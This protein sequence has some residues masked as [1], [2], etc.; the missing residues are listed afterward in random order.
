M[1]LLV[2]EQLSKLLA[3][4][5]INVEHADISTAQFN[6]ETRT[7]TLP[8]WSESVSND[9]YDL[10]TSHE[11]GHA[12]YT[13]VKETKA[14]L[15]DDKYPNIHF[16]VNVVEDSRIERMIKNTYPGLKKN[17]HNG[18]KELYDQD[19]FKLKDTE[20]E[21]L[22][23]IDRLNLNEKIGNFTLINFSDKEQHFA[24][25]IKKTKT[26]KEVVELSKELYVYSK[27]E[28]YLK[29]M[30]DEVSY[31]E[32]SLEDEDI[33][34][35]DD[36]D[37]IEIDNRYNFK[38]EKDNSKIIKEIQKLKE[39]IEKFEDEKETQGSHAGDN[40]FSNFQPKAKTQENLEKSVENIVVN[41][42][43]KLYLQFPELNHKD[44][45]Y[46]YKKVYN[47]IRDKKG[48]FTNKLYLTKIK[49]E[50]K[51]TVE[52]MI[53]VFETKKA[54]SFYVR[55]KVA[56]TGTIDTSK[57]FSYKYNEDIFKKVNVVPEGKNHGMI[58]LFDWSGSMVSHTKLYNC[59]KQLV[60]TVLFCRKMNIPYRV[61][62]FGCEVHDSNSHSKVNSFGYPYYGKRVTNN[63]NIKYKNYDIVSDDSNFRIVE[64]LNSEM[65]KKEYDTV[66]EYFANVT[67]S[68]G[69]GTDFGFGGT[70]LTEA[71]HTIDYVIKEFKEQHNVEICNLLVI[72]DGINNQLYHFRYNDHNQHADRDLI[73][74]RDNETK[75]LYRTES[76][77]VGMLQTKLNAIK[78]KHKCNVIGFFLGET[79]D[80]NQIMYRYGKRSDSDLIRKQLKNKNCT[81]I[82]DCGYQEYHIVN[83]SSMNQPVEIADAKTTRGLTT[84][85]NK[86]L[87]KKN[88]NKIV[89]SKFVETISKQVV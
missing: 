33:I 69:A 2:K 21:D 65:N 51:K 53:K 54:A 31:L 75:K 18:Y 60:S 6:L 11:V 79:Y 82:F 85:F 66:M 67:S 68:G 44:F 38:P 84:S 23:L 88:L 32:A 39:K 22:P 37:N 74:V 55:N 30:E 57:L 14:I 9:V 35:I 83:V 43:R 48:I 89:L 64:I 36:S 42:D 5:N 12:L 24:E 41:S 58:I 61:F 77:D 17:Y 45:V 80:I 1:N 50:V 59:F 73:L 70:P 13:P 52:Y 72:T 27:E 16:F 40:K 10:L 28:Q 4:E 34:Q 87:K 63:K 7:L 47:L 25:R 29:S 15:T 76:Y 19:F 20:I 46:D 81:T 62:L 71:C 78:D 86:F 8:N 26:F 49:K 3:T 56:K